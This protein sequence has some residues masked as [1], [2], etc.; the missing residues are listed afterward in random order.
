MAG[1]YRKRHIDRDPA[2]GI[3]PDAYGAIQAARRGNCRVAA[4]HLYDAAP[5]IQG[6][7]GGAKAKRDAES[8]RLASIIVAQHCSPGAARV[9]GRDHYAGFHGTGRR[10]KRRS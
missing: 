3:S 6:G 10:R 9:R 2:P 4:K 8:F 5:H 1:R 7:S